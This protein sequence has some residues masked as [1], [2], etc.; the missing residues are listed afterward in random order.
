MLQQLQVRIQPTGD[1]VIFVNPDGESEVR[2]NGAVVAEIEAIIEAIPVGQEAILLFAVE[3]PEEFAYL[4]PD[5]PVT[6]VVGKVHGRDMCRPPLMK[7]AV[8]H[9]PLAAVEAVLEAG[10]E[11]DEDIERCAYCDGE[12]CLGQPVREVEGVP[13]RRYAHKDCG[14]PVVEAGYSWAG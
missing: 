9:K 7:R 4:T 2:T 13:G 3:I 8:T 5:S 14:A 10:Y 11:A 12:I 6:A 1:G